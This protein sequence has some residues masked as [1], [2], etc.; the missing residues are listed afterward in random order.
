MSS[1][2]LVSPFASPSKAP[3]VTSVGA[4]PPSDRMTA[5]AADRSTIPIHFPTLYRS[6]RHYRRTIRHP[7]SNHPYD[8]QILTDHTDVVYSVR[9]VGDW[10]I[11]GGRDRTIRFWHLGDLPQN[12][13]SPCKCGEAVLVKT[14]ESDHEGSV[15][16]LVTDISVDDG[17]G[18][19]VSGSSDGTAA[20]WTI[21]GLS[22]VEKWGKASEPE[23]K[24]ERIATLTGHAD[25]IL[26]VSLSKAH[27]I[28][29]SRD[30]TL[31]VYARSNFALVRALRPH[32]TAINAVA[33][34]PD[35]QTEQVASGSSDGSWSISN[36]ITGQ[37]VLRVSNHTADEES[38]T[39]KGIACLVWKGGY[40]LTGSSGGL[41]RLHDAST[42]VLLGVFTGHSDTIR[43]VDLYLF[44][45]ASPVE[46]AEADTN[47]IVVSGSYDHS[48]RMWDLAT[49]KVLRRF[50]E[51]IGGSSTMPSLE[52]EGHSNLVLD[53][54]MDQGR[55][56]S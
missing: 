23:L 37:E 34:H 41:A 52:D 3:H 5:S 39:G 47:G 18:I 50:K 40:I 10:L 12:D 2:V 24:V 27:I 8:T 7:S 20:V 35:R 4:D 19:L 16:N 15:L 48:V 26:A 49:G 31:R 56:V 29:G 46:P 45:G 53:V 36:L 55:L 9:F 42:G 33:T 21:G 6:L 51:G 13:A 30:T 17:R 44:S 38:R 14:V 54:Q 22:R 1:G 43:S 28:T 32:T 11:S 25:G